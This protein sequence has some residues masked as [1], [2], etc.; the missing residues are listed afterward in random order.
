[1]SIKSRKFS[2]GIRLKGTT[3]AATLDGEIRNDSASKRTKVYHDTDGID[4][5]GERE[6]LTS[7]QSQ[8]VTNKDIDADNNTISNLETDNLK[9]GVLN[10][11][12]SGAA[13]DTEIPSALAVKTALEGQNDASEIEVVTDG[14]KTIQEDVPASGKTSVQAAL[15]NLDDESDDVRALTGTAQNDR[16]LGTVTGDIVPDN[17]TIKAAIQSLDLAATDH[18]AATEAHGATG[19]V[20]GTTNTQTVQ[21]KTMDSTNVFSGSIE[22]P[23]RLDVKQDT[24]AN[25]TTYAGTATD[26]QFVFATDTQKMY[27]II[28]NALAPV[29]GG[30]AT[31]FEVDQVNTFSVGEGIYHNGTTW[32]AGQA[33]DANTLAYYVVIEATGTSFIAADFG[34]IVDVQLGDNTAN[35]LVAGEYY[36]LSDSVAG[37]PTSTEPSSGFSNPLFYVESIDASTPSAQV[38]VLQIKVYRPGAI[39]GINL[40]DLDNVSVPSPSDNQVLAYN[41]ANSRWEAADAVS[42]ASDV[43]YNN[44]TSG[45]TATDAQAAIDEVEG[46]VETLETNPAITDMD[47]L[48]D[49]D[50]ASPSKGDIL[51]R[52]SVTGNYEALPV[53][54]NGSYL[55]TDDSEDLGVKYSS[56]IAGTLN[57]VSEWESFDVTTDGLGTIAGDEFFKRRVG[58]TLQVR[59]FLTTGTPSASSAIQIFLPDGLQLDAS[60][61]GVARSKIFGEAIYADPT[62]TQ[63]PASSRG[64]WVITD[65]TDVNTDR[66]YIVRRVDSDASSGVFEDD[67]ANQLVGTSTKLTVNFEVPIQGWTS[68][69]DAAVQNKVQPIVEGAGNGGGTVDADVTPIDFTE[70]RDNTDSWD[71]STFTAP[72]TGEYKVDG[73]IFI[74][75]G[76][77]VLQ[78]RA[79]VNGNYTKIL[80]NSNSTGTL[81]EFSGTVS[82]NEGDTLTL[83]LNVT[84]TLSNSTT[85]HHIHIQKLNDTG[86]ITGTFENINSSSLSFVEGRD[87]GNQSYTSGTPV[88]FN[89]VKDTNNEWDGDTFT[90]SRDMRVNITGSI[91]LA[92]PASP[93]VRVYKN[94]SP[95]NR[96]GYEI[97][98]STAVHGFASTVDLA[99]GDT[100]YIGLSG[101]HTLGNGIPDDHYIY[102]T[103]SADTESIIKNLNDGNNY[104]TQLKTFAGSIT[105][106]GVISDLT[107][108]NLDLTKKYRFKFKGNSEHTTTIDGDKFLYIS[109]NV[110]GIQ[111]DLQR[112]RSTACRFSHNIDSPVFTPTSTTLTFEIINIQQMALLA[113]EVEL[114]ELPDNYLTTTKFD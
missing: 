95:L 77:A 19:A 43:T 97:S 30:G 78:I 1:M 22:T 50:N 62:Q 103:E 113:A 34:R 23:S 20:M 109:S 75:S 29:G 9:A 91:R 74:T 53:A 112:S 25:L 13:T 73:N 90:A 108:N 64:R 86:V 37:Q 36:F 10:T 39:E 84:R 114:V 89:Q 31:Q 48:T 2:K 104:L 55:V 56:A 87:N 105:S 69:V 59:G 52:N 32:V 65:R 92:S 14:S 82:L 79:Y 88:I 45:L 111:G 71:G 15:D 61:I 35:S 41:N 106:T 46:R 49:V 66:L 72:E 80:G 12:L 99:E 5:A 18:I 8:T 76:S 3:D 38:A 110:S 96:C 42:D 63:I 44:T 102:I 11:D 6:V 67:A 54:P 60:K 7:D 68:G 70:T 58:D 81:I 27:Q 93:S 21:N 101:N 57:P 16:N 98:D 17:T 47:S 107:F 83:R 40:D 4:A 26:G 51:V 24:E 85:A 100:M 28:D 33:D 94:G